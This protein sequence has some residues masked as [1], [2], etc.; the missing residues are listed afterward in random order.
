MPLGNGALTA[1][2]WP[3]AS[4]GGVGLYIGHQSAMS[5]WTELFKIAQVD[6]ALSPAP[7]GA[8]FNATHDIATA[9]L[10]LFLGGSSFSDYAV[11]LRVWVDAAPDDALYVEAASRDPARLFSLAATVSSVRPPGVWH[12][13]PSFSAC[14]AVSSQPDVLV[15]PLPPAVR[16]RAPPP[17]A[18]ADVVRHASGA[19]RPT[20]RLAA[21]GRL[22][23]LGAFQPGS[24]VIFHRNADSDGLAVNET[25]VQQGVGSLVETTPDFWRDNQFGLALDG[26]GGPALVRTGAASLA[27]AAPAA[28]F[29]LRAT[30]LAVQTDS[31]DEWLTELSAL[32]AAG[33]GAAA[34]RPAHEA[35]WANFWSRSY[36]AVNM[37]NSSALAAL[38][39]ADDLS[40]EGR[41]FVAPRAA[42]PAPGALPVPNALLWLR[43]STL[44]AS[45]ANGSRV[46]TW[47]NDVPQNGSGVAQA[48]VP[49][50]PLFLS[51]GLGAGVPAV[52]FDGA[53]AFL[54]NGDLA[55][56]RGDYSVMAVFRDDGSS[57]GT[58]APCCSGVVILRGS[59]NGISTVPAADYVDDDGNNAQGDPVVAFLDGPGTNFAG[60]CKSASDQTRPPPTTDSLSPEPFPRTPYITLSRR[61]KHPRPRR[62]RA[63]KLPAGVGRALRRRLPAGAGA[64][65]RR[66]QRGRRAD[67]RAQRGG[68]PRPLLPWR[69]RRGR[70][71]R[72]RSLAGRGR[73]HVGLLQ[74]GLPVPAAAGQVHSDE[75]RRLPA[76]ACLRPDA[77]RACH[78]VTGGDLALEV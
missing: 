52:L 37:T 71:L 61:S 76:V 42:A 63:C 31:S 60:H 40:A 41:R 50:Q 68:R 10:L 70:R 20:R 74:A 19:A 48:A 53:A 25:L 4:S 47:P 51:D 7:S 34:A 55:T 57:G 77:L 14:H 32:V 29:E 36:I 33:R 28:A 59:F 75:G 44:A 58:G 17:Q 62:G 22:P 43:A 67:R 6:V 49:K 78:P 24:I 26:G 11:R 72:P 13:S 21:E 35:W 9:S 65:R 3:N 30:A 54:E 56:H 66:A 12:Y 64:A 15:D 46:A 73:G 16:L 5:S 18:P 8:Y 27:S 1:L 2:A 39:G 23:A 45:L 69:A 38:V